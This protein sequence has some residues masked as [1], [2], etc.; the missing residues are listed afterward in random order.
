MDV[1]GAR[2]VLMFVSLDLEMK[3]MIVTATLSLHQFVVKFTITAF[4]ITVL[5]SKF[6]EILII[7]ITLLLLLHNHKNVP[8]PTT[9]KKFVLQRQF[10][11]HNVTGVVLMTQNL[12]E[13]NTFVRVL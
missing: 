9:A 10:L 4:V 11:H 6:V 8:A 12:L 13:V 3:I 1:G 2:M 5:L 7:P